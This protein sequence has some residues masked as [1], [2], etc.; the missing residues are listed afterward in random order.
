MKRY[1][2][3]C[4]A[5]I[6]SLFSVAFTKDNSS[7]KTNNYW[8]ALDPITASQVP[9]ATIPSNQANDPYLCPVTAT[10]YCSQ[11]F[12]EYEVVPG[13]SPVRYRGKATTAGVQHMKTTNP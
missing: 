10:Y 13:S 3:G 5:I 6:L 4:I 2:F 1:M 12:G 9:Q 7:P 11:V 8:F